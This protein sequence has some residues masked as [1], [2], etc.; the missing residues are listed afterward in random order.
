MSH[1]PLTLGYLESHLWEAVNILLARWMPPTSRPTSFR[2]CSLNAS[3]MFMTREGLNDHITQGCLRKAFKGRASR[4]LAG[5]NL[6]RLVSS[7][8][9]TQIGRNVR[10]RGRSARRS[11]ANQAQAGRNRPAIRCK[12]GRRANPRT[13]IGRNQAENLRRN[14]TAH[15]AAAA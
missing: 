1:A 8:S 15:L 4:Y 10:A 11:G 3:Q 7:D 12:S 5:V 14:D 2:F 6:E 9:R 13:Q